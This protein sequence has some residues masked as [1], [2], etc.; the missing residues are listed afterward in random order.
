MKKLFT[1][2]KLQVTSYCFLL[3]AFCFLSTGTLFAQKVP[4]ENTPIGNKNCFV[5]LYFGPTIDWFA[6]TTNE[7][8]LKRE[9]AKAGLV[10][11]CNVDIN[12]TPQKM[13]Y[14]STGVLFKYLQGELSFANQ[15]TVT[16]L[17]TTFIRP[18]VRTYQTM[19]L[20]FPTGVK[21]RTIPSKNCVFAGK[22]G[23]YHGFKVG[24]N[25]VDN[26][27]FPGQDLNPE[28]Y[29]TTNRE[30]NKDASLF[31]ESGYFGLG[32]EY[33]F[34]HNI[35]VNANLEYC[36]QFNYFNSNAINNVA[37]AKYKSVIH[38]LHITFGVLF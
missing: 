19:Y 23:L 18:T 37:N 33:V 6:P 13:L 21:F 30:K 16:F 7:F 4:V 26:F 35:R 31:A 29:L 5:E 25:Q 22:L 3:S 1:S 24:G 9:K 15:Y 20:I 38:S 11:G 8:E 34:A 2:Y 10:V 28:Y 27:T 36:C 32:F 12:L 17:D 14:F